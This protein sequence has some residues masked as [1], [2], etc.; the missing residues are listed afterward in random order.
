MLF[1][2]FF[3]E[4]FKSCWSLHNI[5]NLGV[6]ISGGWNGVEFLKSIEIYNPVTNTT[7]SLPQL[8]EARYVHTQDGELACGGSVSTAG[9]TCVKWSSESGSWT[10]SHTLRQSRYFHVSWNTEDGVYLMGGNYGS[11]MKTTELVKA[12]GSAEDG[13]SLKYDTA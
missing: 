9:N 12:D 7:C 3:V 4:K 6:L 5:I 10:Q 11:N 8:P 13:F 1:I 2:F